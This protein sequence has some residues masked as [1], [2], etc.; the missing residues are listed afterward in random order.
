M[1]SPISKETR[2]RSTIGSLIVSKRSPMSA[3]IGVVTVVICFPSG[4]RTPRS[5]QV[6]ESCLCRRA[7]V[8]FFANIAF[9]SRLRPDMSRD[10]CPLGPRL[11]RNDYGNGQ[12]SPE[13]AQGYQDHSSPAKARFDH[14]Q[15]GAFSPYSAA[16]STT[17][18]AYRPS[19]PFVSRTCCSA[20]SWNV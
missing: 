19:I 6:R 13:T 5:V 18:P 10:L 8:G 9:L 15:A 11:L 4:G 7:A 3:P 20:A 14:F 2:R 12:H 17:A 16:R 1:F